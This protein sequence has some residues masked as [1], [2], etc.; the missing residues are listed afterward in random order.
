MTAETPQDRRSFLSNA[1]TLLMAGGLAA[2]YGTFFAM[3]GRYLFPSSRNKAWLFVV[4]A[5]S[6]EP[7]ESMHFVSPTGVTVTITRRSGEA[8]IDAPLAGD[9]LAGRT[10]EKETVD[11]E[12]TG[13][14]GATS[15]TGLAQN[16][17]VALSNVCPHLGCLVHWEA[18]NDRFFCPCHNGVFDPTGK[19]TAGPPA[20]AGQFL[21]EYPLKIVDGSLYIEMSIETVR[22]LPS[23]NS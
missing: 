15:D 18:Q 20:A 7:G 16:S 22:K 2:G 6:I 21:P 4:N 1:S 13:D 9:H 10:S 17:F 23:R 14:M 3:A 12:A 5:L 11:T 8:L 19:A